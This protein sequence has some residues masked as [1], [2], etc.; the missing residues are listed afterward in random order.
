MT[1]DNEEKDC[2]IVALESGV[3]EF[4][5]ISRSMIS[6]LF[7]TETIPYNDKLYRM[8]EVAYHRFPISHTDKLRIE[9][10]PEYRQ[11]LI[12]QA[13]ERRQL[14]YMSPADVNGIRGTSPF[15]RLGIETVMDKFL[16]RNHGVMA[17]T[18]GEFL[19]RARG[20]IERMMG[21]QP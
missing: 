9:I 18:D 11:V 20:E 5:I 3:S 12:D 14:F 10:Y 17:G 16:E 6:S 7:E 4:F 1:D 19:A 8:S 2:V 13:K 21:P 15:K